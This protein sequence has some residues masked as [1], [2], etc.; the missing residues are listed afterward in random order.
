[1]QVVEQGGRADLA[2]RVLALTNS[3]SRIVFEEARADDPKQRCPDIT[4]AKKLLGW[5]PRVSL[6]EGLKKTIEYFASLDL[7]KY[8]E[9]TPAPELPPALPK[10]ICCTLTAVP[11]LSG[12]PLSRR[13]V[14]KF[15]HGCGPISMCIT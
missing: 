11:Q 3:K 5:E 1:M 6:D 13:W 2:D 9:P 10:T 7:S 15:M 8:R 12:M 14:K 4:K